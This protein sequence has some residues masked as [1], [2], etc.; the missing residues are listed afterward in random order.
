MFILRLKHLICIQL[1]LK[2]LCSSKWFSWDL[3]IM[4]SKIIFESVTVVILWETCYLL[5]ITFLI[6]FAQT[7]THYPTDLSSG[8]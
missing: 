5:R 7:L 2:K 1:Q 3:F 4:F 6:Y 8:V